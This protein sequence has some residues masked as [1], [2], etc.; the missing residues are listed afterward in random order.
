MSQFQPLTIVICVDHAS[1][2]GGQAKVAI[3]S[4][5]GLKRAGA[6]PILF[7]A[8]GPIDPRLEAAGVEVVCLGQDDLLSNPS[9]VAAARQ[10]LWNARAAT[11]LGKL[12]GETPR[13]RTV[14]HVHGWAKALSPSIVA[15]LRAAALPAVFTVHEYFLFCPNGGFYN[16]QEGA[17]CGLRPLSLSCLTTHCDVR[18]YP[19][20]LWRYGRLYAARRWLRM[21]EA[22]SDY[23]CISEHQAQIIGSLLPAGARMY[24][25]SNPIEAEDLGPKTDPTRGDLIFVGRLSP[26]K[27][28]A[29]F[30]EAAARAGVVP[31]LIGDGPQGDELRR[32]YPRARL[33]GWLTPNETRARMRAA[34]A[35]VF[36]SLWYETQGLVAVEAKAM[37]TPVIVSDV[38]AGRE[39]IDD[40][41]S[42]IWFKSGSVELLASALTKI[43]DDALV[44]RLSRGAY[45]DYWR[46]P[47][48]IEAHIERLSAIYADLAP[49]RRQI[50]GASAA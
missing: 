46:A 16:Y 1:V 41:K 8:V 5:L 28:A 33:L 7:A 48:T 36:P 47:M 50:A 17:V 39:A 34:R 38:C 18:N 11:A 21:A 49:A 9:R 3:E 32:R 27:G 23:I 26:E 43:G 14:V 31:T 15:P 35:V 10:G 40:G 13:D 22:F 12:L 20:K 30:I 45:E 29:L 42:G 19:H 2:N 44:T 25:L 37:G 24:R 6:R 4:A